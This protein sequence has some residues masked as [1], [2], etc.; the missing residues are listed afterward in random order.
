ML[1]LGLQFGDILTNFLKVI[2][3][4]FLICA[5]LIYSIFD[6]LYQIFMAI[7][8]ARIFSQDN[9]I[10]LA[11]K[12]YV[13]I[14][15]VAL[16]FVAYALLRAIADP[17]GAAKG[18]MAVGKIIP[19]ILKA[20]ILIAFVPTIFN[21]AYKV[22]DTIFSTHVIENLL[23]DTDALPSDSFS[24]IGHTMGN[25]VFIS[26]FYPTSKTVGDACSNSNFNFDSCLESEK[27][28]KEESSSILRMLAYSNP[29][30]IAYAA[31][32]D[33]VNFITKS[34]DNQISLKDI[35]NQVNETGEY[36]KYEPFA[37]NAADG[38]INYNWIMQGLVGCFL[39]Y[40]FLNFCIDLGVRAIKL[41]Y[42]QL[43]APIPILTIII[44]GQKKIFDNWK[45]GTI[46]TFLEVFIRVIIVVFC[47]YMIQ[48]L[49]SAS[50]DIWS[51]SLLGEPSAFVRIMARAF[52][53]IGILI[54]MKQAPKLISDMFGISSGSFKL[55]IGEKLGEMAF[56]GG[57]ANKAQ[58]AITGALGAG[59]TSKTNGGSFMKGAKYGLASGWKDGKGKPNQF[60]AQ[61]QGLYSTLG[62]KGKAG[63]FG[64]QAFM[65]KWVD[66]T[67][68]KYTDDYKDRILS[69]RINSAQ[70]YHNSGSA[71]APHYSKEYSARVDTKKNEIQAL[72]GQLDGAK[73]ALGNVNTHNQEKIAQGRVAFE[74]QK[75]SKLSSLN[76]TLATQERAFESNKLNQVTQLDNQLNTLKSN[77]VRNGVT[78]DS[79]GKNEQVQ[80]LQE[81]IGSIRSQQFD[82]SDITKQISDLNNLKYEQTSN[83]KTINAQ[84]SMAERNLTSQIEN[85]SSQIATKDA[86]I[87][88]KTETITR[89]VY[90]P[91]TKKL[92]KVTENVSK[93]ESE[94]FKAAIKDLEDADETFKNQNKIFKARVNEKETNT[95]LNT[96]EG[97]R[98]TAALGKNIDKIGKGSSAVDTKEEKKPDNDKK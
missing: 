50:A 4:F 17:E 19:N 12:I 28:E 58:G 91:G 10:N 85:I 59:Y 34:N 42:Y 9:Y 70:D 5:S 23:F 20:I 57:A 64:G 7:A 62:Y 68:N 63:A 79:L 80:K 29:V 32:Y 49:P 14:G 1:I 94:S 76:D 81:Q 90:N 88:E 74:N 54:F 25:E 27:I 45:K 82:K 61:R 75:Q 93:V 84:A 97:Q 22:Q 38:S 24:N 36:I 2:Y 89:N 53:I 40:V 87:N 35:Y 11:N 48:H 13:V 96:E 31:I 26:F 15:V 72:Q 65:D 46:S 56:L 86:E 18:E 92:D 33:F 98:L 52:I 95:W 16:F 66:D 21:I 69:A 83:Y 3:T 30:T 73:S 37:V 51:N 47:I 44:P 60:G 6:V 78:I 67:R 39:I 43:I 71:I 41:V 55:G 77:L 8:S